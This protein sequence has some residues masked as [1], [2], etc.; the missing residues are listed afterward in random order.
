M[1]N[2]L[3]CNTNQD[4][5]IFT[6]IIQTSVSQTLT[7]IIC[8]ANFGG[9][10]KF[11]KPFKKKFYKNNCPV[12]SCIF[13]FIFKK[14]FANFLTSMPLLVIG[15]PQISCKPVLAFGLVWKSLTAH[16][17]LVYRSALVLL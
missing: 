2:T 11:L 5:T 3:K 16:L 4:I 14:M 15:V 12:C 13:Y 10:K 17:T 9:F 1:E 7:I 8:D 6:Q